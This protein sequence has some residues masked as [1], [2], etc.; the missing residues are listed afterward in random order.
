MTPEQIWEEA[1]AA[2][3][4]SAR[5]CV[6]EPMIVT[7]RTATEQ[8]TYYE[9]QG[10]CGFA[11]IRFAGNTAFGRW[12]KRVGH[13]TP[14]SYGGG[15]SVHVREGGQSYEIKCAYARAFAGVLNENGIK[16]RVEAFLD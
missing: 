12:A 16:A 8:K 15:L 5:A 6:P 4:A 13:A 14:A 3:L 7:S 11:S 1:E 10:W 9:P 2:G